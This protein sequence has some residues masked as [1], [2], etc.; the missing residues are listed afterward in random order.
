[1]VLKE[2]QQRILESRCRAVIMIQCA[3]RLHRGVHV[4]Q[5]LKIDFLK[6]KELHCASALQIKGTFRTIM[7]RKAIQ[8]RVKQT[9]KRLGSTLIIQRW[10][11]DQNRRQVDQRMAN[12]ELAK[13]RLS[14]SETIQRKVRQ[15]LAC[16]QLVM[17]RQ[18]RDKIVALRE[19]KIPALSVDGVGYVLPRCVLKDAVRILKR[20]SAERYS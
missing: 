1:M 10:Y 6:Q 5:V 13:A 17:L 4:L 11:R 9:R 12:A 2:K 7:F 19:K 14:A 3:W 18:K 20:K 15:L 16:L 8:L